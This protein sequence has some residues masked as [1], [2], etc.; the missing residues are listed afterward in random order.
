MAGGVQI[1][2]QEV[3]GARYWTEPSSLT[4]GLERTLKTQSA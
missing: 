2:L 4:D 1:S 3:E